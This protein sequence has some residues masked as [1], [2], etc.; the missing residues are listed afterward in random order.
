MD[1]FSHALS[2]KW[3]TDYYQARFPTIWEE[4]TKWTWNFGDFN[5]LLKTLFSHLYTSLFECF[6]EL[7]KGC[8]E[9]SQL[10]NVRVHWS[11]TW[12]FSV[13]TL[14]SSKAIDRDVASPCSE[15]CPFEVLEKV[16]LFWNAS[17]GFQANQFRKDLG[18]WMK[19]VFQLALSL[20]RVNGIQ[21]KFSL[22]GG[23]GKQLL[24]SS[25]PPLICVYFWM[26]TIYIWSAWLAC[27]RP[28]S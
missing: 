19:T 18:D 10:L 16:D 7:R 24:L 25:S 23:G 2:I 3:H 6:K 14:D 22:L 1:T 26:H 15:R 27:S 12:D 4:V 21:S 9:L 20:W 11:P 8:L 13:I 28:D 5:S 17:P